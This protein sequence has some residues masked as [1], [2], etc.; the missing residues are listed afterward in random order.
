MSKAAMTV[1]SEQ[2]SAEWLGVF[3][4]PLSAA[5]RDQVESEPVVRKG[6][7]HGAALRAFR[8]DFILAIRLCS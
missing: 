5:R 8:I 1:E 7:V 4:E 6:T 2:R 3:S